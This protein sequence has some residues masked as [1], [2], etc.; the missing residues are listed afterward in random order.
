MA[1]LPGVQT[2]KDPE[3]LDKACT[4]CCSA[5]IYRTEGISGG[6]IKTA[7]AQQMPHE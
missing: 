7:G 2:I 4:A 5:G 1:G 3:H 6:C